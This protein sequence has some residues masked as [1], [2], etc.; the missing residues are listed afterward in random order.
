VIK[1]PHLLPYDQDAN[2]QILEDFTDTT[3]FKAM[4]FSSNSAIL[5]PPSSREDV[6]RHLGSWLRHFHSWTSAPEQAALRALIPQD[7]P[8]RKLKRSYTYD[9]FL[10]ILKNFPEILDGHQKT[11]ENI[12]EVMVKEF[13][14]PPTEEEPNW[15]I[16]HGDFWSGK[17]VSSYF[18]IFNIGAVLTLY[19]VSSSPKV[20]GKSRHRLMGTKCSL[21]IGNSLSLVIDAVTSVKS[22]VTCV[23]GRYTMPMTLGFLSW[24]ELFG[25]MGSCLRRWLFGL[26]FM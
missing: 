24:R 25:D 17:Y 21:L 15:G 2:T 23:S 9:C 11:L 14:K 6:G 16:I 12:R 10:E 13:E 4:L 1:A 20:G 8:M 5:I 19:E 7:D 18:S 3:G 22:L 26:R